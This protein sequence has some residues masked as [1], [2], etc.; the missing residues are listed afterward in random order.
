MP[1]WVLSP[2]PAHFCNSQD[3]LAGG[4][5]CGYRWPSLACALADP[6]V[7]AVT[8]RSSSQWPKALQ[9]TVMQHV[10]AATE[11]RL[12]SVDA[13]LDAVAQTRS[14][15]TSLATDPMLAVFSADDRHVLLAGAFSFLHSSFV[16]PFLLEV[17]TVEEA[18]VLPCLLL[19]LAACFHRG[20]S[21]LGGTR[22][23]FWTLARRAV[24]NVSDQRLRFLQDSFYNR[25]A[26]AGVSGRC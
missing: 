4:A 6:E 19:Q 8:C 22:F 21:P 24:P 11:A 10:L 1:P 15:L 13:V 7:C 25:W 2:L 9:Q 26:S 3:A 23:L 18:P 17:C 20:E 5:F 16:A 12:P 14:A